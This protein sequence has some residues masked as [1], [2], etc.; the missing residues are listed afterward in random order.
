MK[1][2]VKLS[3]A[4][5]VAIIMVGSTAYAALECNVSINTAKTEYSKNEEV[6]VSVNLSDIQSERGVIAFGATLD[7]DKDSL[8]LVKMEGKNNWSNPSYN[9][10][11]GKLVMDRSN[12]TN[13]NETLLEITFKVNENSKQ[14]TTVTLKDISVSDGTTPIKNISSI[15]KDI[16]VNEVVIIKPDSTTSDSNNNTVDNTNNN[17]S[18]ETTENSSTN[19]TTTSNNQISNSNTTNS[20]STNKNTVTIT[21]TTD[22]S[23]SNGKLP[24]TGVDNNAV[25]ILLFIATI[26]AIYFFV[27]LVRMRKQ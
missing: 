9:E 3:L 8:T 12:V 27:K 2:I 7:Y 1:K 23:T 16:T 20:T 22:V 21:T 25:N 10:A 13:N 14:N 5:L 6:V 4:L 11:N 15:S 18:T 24:Q 17:T 26:A 19:N